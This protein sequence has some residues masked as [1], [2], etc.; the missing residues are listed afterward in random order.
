MSIGE[1]GALGEFFGSI[2]V[3][4]TL[5]YLAI[6]IRENTRSTTTSIYQSAMDG[7]IEL[8]RALSEADI[9]ELYFRTVSDLESLS[10]AELFRAKNLHRMWLAHVYKLFRLYERGVLPEDEWKTTVMDAVRLNGDQKQLHMQ[11]RAENPF[12]N[13]LYAEIDK[14]ESAV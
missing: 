9:G 2:F 12:F 10:E 11:F 6:Q 14:Y 1:L 4:V 8:N 5:I 3:L 13:D 7:Y